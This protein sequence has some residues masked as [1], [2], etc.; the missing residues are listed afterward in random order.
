[1]T[2]N[3]DADKNLQIIVDAINTV[4]KKGLSVHITPDGY[5]QVIN[6]VVYDTNKK[7]GLEQVGYS[8]AQSDILK[9]DV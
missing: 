3:Y 5:L 8:V 6:T 4:R 9:D 2:T 7:L 1:M